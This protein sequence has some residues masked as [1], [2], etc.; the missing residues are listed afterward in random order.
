MKSALG[1]ILRHRSMRKGASFVVLVVAALPLLASAQVRAPAEREFQITKISKNLIPTP[2]YGP[3]KYRAAANVQWLEVEVEFNAA[4]EWTDELTLKY[5]IL[6]N[7][8]LLTGDVTHINI[9]GGLN[10][11]VMYVL[12]CPT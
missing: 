7:G 4:P 1:S 5:Y 12:E 11:S 3:G 8:R 9:P 2:D 6:F 10:R